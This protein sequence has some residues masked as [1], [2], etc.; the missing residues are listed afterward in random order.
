MSKKPA[1]VDLSSPDL[2]A[3]KRKAFE[4]LFPGVLADGVLDATRLGE[5]LDTQVAQ[6]ADARERFGLMW[7]GKQ[8]AVRSLLKPSRGALVPDLENSIDF[9]TAQNVF[10]EGD[11]LEVLKLMQKA[12]NDKVKLIY[13]DPPYNTGNDF[14]YN[15][16]FS[17]GLRGYLEFTGQ[18]DDEGKL[19]S[20]NAETAGRKH[21]RWLSMM[22][23]RLLLGR[24]LLRPDGVI[25]VSI[26]DNELHNL[27]AAMDE[28]FG[29]ENLIGVFI[30]RKK[31]TLSFRDEYMIPI[32]EYIV[33]Y[34]GRG[35]PKIR[36][37]RWTSE[38]TVSV[39][40]V[41]K[42]QNAESTKTIR[43]GAALQGHDPPPR[44]VIEK[45]PVAL[46]SQTLEYLDDAVFVDGIL[47][48]DVRIR[49]RFSS[50]QD[51]LDTSSIEVSR[52]GAAYVVPEEKEKVIRPISILFDY[53]KD[54]ASYVYERYQHRKAIS[55]RQATAELEVMMGA[56]V[57]DNPKPVE[58]IAS[59]IAYVEMQD[60]D[61][62]LDY[63]AGSGTTATAA[64]VQNERDGVDRHSFSVNLP[65]PIAERR[66]NG[67]E[68]VAE[69]TRERIRRALD[70][71]AT[72]GL[73]VLSLASSAFRS[74]EHVGG[75][76][77]DLSETTL[78]APRV[79]DDALVAE[80]LL[81]EGV[82]LDTPWQRNAVGGSS[83]VV[84][85]GVAVVVSLDITDEVVD[86]AL[87]LKP[88]V[89]VFLEDGFAAQDVVKANAFT[90]ARNAGVTMK[91]V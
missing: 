41:F 25:F 71:T 68:H 76:L 79:N 62:V 45:G 20:T 52:G 83:V 30:W 31:Y 16:D 74:G 66:A 39:N 67:F 65:E 33:G 86:D 80:V 22:Y 43:M 87:A 89:L 2:A 59:L 64:A 34:K 9:D 35:R 78:K 10:I 14:V 88:R 6:A 81:K 49:G 77:F 1:K 27:R 46:Q 19:T 91:T 56:K 57:F 47:E 53:T 85:D 54:D 36:D 4:D 51:R 44:F 11:N 90:R 28:I 7:A 69:I 32:H 24:N 70:R 8:E 42:S 21:S 40:P 29:P 38:D 55:T 73:R 15:D 72:P 82:T 75:E 63:F 18:L 58:L 37:P 12:Y 23:P 84:A 3:E 50:G 60:G 26:D 5:L 13:I 48:A 17:D 61:I